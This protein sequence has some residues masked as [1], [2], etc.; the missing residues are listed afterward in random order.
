M[1]AL[2]INK[3]DVFSSGRPFLS[4][5]LVEGDGRK[6]LQDVTPKVLLI[7]FKL[8]TSLESSVSVPLLERDKRSLENFTLSSHFSIV[9]YTENVRI[10]SL[11]VNIH[12][13]IGDL[14]SNNDAVSKRSMFSTCIRCEVY[15]TFLKRV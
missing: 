2:T 7:K 13:H 14:S 11:F 12:F 5:L 8:Q 4:L 3:Y 1:T 15:R 10:F 6:G 9:Y